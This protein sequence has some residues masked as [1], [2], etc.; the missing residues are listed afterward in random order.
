LGF[1]YMQARYYDPVIGVRVRLL[2]LRA[3]NPHS[4]AHDP[5]GFAQAGPGYFNRERCF[6]TTAGVA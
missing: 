4:I 6:F 3:A 5:V 1:T 2:S